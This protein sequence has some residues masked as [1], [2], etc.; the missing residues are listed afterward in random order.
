MTVLNGKDDARQAANWSGR[1]GRLAAELPAIRPE[2]ALTSLDTVSLS[3]PTRLSAIL[4]HLRGRW[5]RQQE[6]AEK[7]RAQ[8]FLTG[9]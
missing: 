3:F 2:V 7:L 4:N 9:A 5:Q 1:L 6:T 8:E